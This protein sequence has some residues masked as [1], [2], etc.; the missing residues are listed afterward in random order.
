MPLSAA[1]QRR[2]ARISG[3]T[4]GE[5]MEDFCQSWAVNIYLY[6]YLDPT[7]QSDNHSLDFSRAMF[8][9]A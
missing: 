5:R 3:A 7:G 9:S 6:I 1:G 8:C 2:S 4:G